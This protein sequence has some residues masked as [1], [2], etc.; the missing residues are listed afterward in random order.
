MMK[1]HYIHA[2]NPEEFDEKVNEFIKD[3][4]VID[5]KPYQ[6]MDPNGWSA[7]EGVHVQFYLDAMIMYEGD[8]QCYTNTKR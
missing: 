3:K 1:V 8:E 4:K 2:E 7:S 5:I 6:Y